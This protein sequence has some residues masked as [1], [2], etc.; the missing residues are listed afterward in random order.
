MTDDPLNNCDDNIALSFRDS[1][2]GS[3]I[4]DVTS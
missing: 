1:T 2:E 4:V 3:D